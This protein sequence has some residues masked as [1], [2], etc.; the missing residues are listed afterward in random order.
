MNPHL[1]WAAVRTL[2]ALALA[3]ALVP[4]P[5]SAQDRIK[6]L[7]GYD[8]YQKVSPQL[9][10][11]V[12]PGT[13]NGTWSSDSRSFVYELDAKRYRFDVASRTSVEI[14]AVTAPA[15]RGGRGGRGGAGIERGRQATSADAPDG[16]L[17]AYYRD[18]NLW[19]SDSAGANESAVTT[20]GDE[21]NRIKYGTASWVYGEELGQSTAMWWSPDEPQGRLLPLRRD[22]GPRLQP[23]ARSDEDSEPQRRRGVSQGR[24]R[25]SR[26]RSLRLRRGDQEDHVDRRAGRQALRQRGRRPL[27]VSRVVDRRWPGAAVQP[28]EPPPERAG[29][30]RRQPRDGRDP[31]RRPR[32]VAD[33]LG[34]QSAADAVP[35]GS[36]ALHL[37]V[38]AQRLGQPL[39]L[40][41]DRQA[42]RI[43]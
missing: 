20:D 2:S 22:A 21:K 26:R 18:R 29:A 25:E 42:D 27:R 43:R 4:G 33:R 31:R 13:V 8:R 17:K 41:F 6:T 19:V 3:G 36:E 5:I 35:E 24:R 34:R 10:G 37:G 12:R 1:S 16:K 9:N 28:H 23:A 38:G 7:P 39:S 15:G 14:G 30:R 40:R 32:R 11:A